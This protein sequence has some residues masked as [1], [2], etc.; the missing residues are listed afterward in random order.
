MCGLVEMTVIAKN[1]ISQ[2]ITIILYSCSERSRHEKEARDV[3]NI[4]TASYPR[5]IL[6]LSVS[7]A[8]RF[9]LFFRSRGNSSVIAVSIC[10]LERKINICVMQGIATEIIEAGSSTV[11][12]ML[13]LL[14]NVCE[15]CWLF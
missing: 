7:L 3:K 15:M 11:N 14:C 5:H 10:M 9:Y 12:L 1:N 6:R 2:S 4:L 8:S 13:C